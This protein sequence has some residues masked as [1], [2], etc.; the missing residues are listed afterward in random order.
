MLENKTL[1]LIGAGK[2]GEA[3]VL[4]LLKNS[5]LTQKDIHATVGREQS[6]SRVKEKLNVSVSTNNK[7]AISGADIVIVAVKPQKMEAVLEELKESVNE[8]QLVISVAASISTSFVEQ[9]LSGSIPVCKSNAKYTFSYECW[10][11][12]PLRR[13]LCH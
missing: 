2:L 12:S 3:L 10:N 5:P 11:D 4:G 1:A 7:D 13:C 8:N 6:I 9:R